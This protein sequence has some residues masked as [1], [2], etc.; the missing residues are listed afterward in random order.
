[1][2]AVGF[3]NALLLYI[4]YQQF[5]QTQQSIVCIIGSHCSAVIG[6]K[7]GE[8]FGI[9]NEL[10]GIAYYSAV[11]L[12][13]LVLLIY[14]KVFTFAVRLGLRLASAASVAFSLYLLGIQAF[15][16]KTFCFR[17]LMAI[18]INILLFIAILITT[19]A[20][21]MPNEIRKEE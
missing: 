5:L 6:S 20:H 4:Q 9:K 11:T 19:K 17:C 3:V 13:S 1:L 18:T 16:L 8:T 10:F 12:V 14:P 7:Y 21:I 2:A 15:T